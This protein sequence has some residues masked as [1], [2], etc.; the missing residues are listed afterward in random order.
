MR[1]H[2][3]SD[4]QGIITTE[5]SEEEFQVDLT[6]EDK[7]FDKDEFVLVKHEGKISI[8]HFTGLVAGVER[9]VYTMCR[10]ILACEAKI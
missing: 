3:D 10:E 9:N 2:D 5:R 6:I 8:K 4:I 1:A 7:T